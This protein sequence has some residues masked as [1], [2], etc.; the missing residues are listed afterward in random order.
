MRLTQFSLA[1]GLFSALLWSQCTP[2]ASV[3]KTANPSVEVGP[4]TTTVVEDEEGNSAATTK[5]VADRGSYVGES[6]RHWQLKHTKL[7]LKFDWKRRAVIGEATLTL[8]PWFY[9]QDSL[10]LN[11]VGFKN[12][13]VYRLVDR[14][15]MATGKSKPMKKVWKEEPQ[16]FQYRNDKHIVIHFPKAWAKYEDLNL[17][18]S[19]TAI[20]DSVTNGGSAAISQDKGLYFIIPDSTAPDKPYQIWTQGETAGNRKW[21]P[22]IDEPNQRCT[23]EMVLTVDTAYK[24][25]SNGVLQYSVNNQDGTRT[26]AWYMD[27]PHAPY[28]FMLAVGKFAV[29]KDKWKGIDLLYYVEPKFGKDAKA[30]FGRTPAMLDFFSERLGVNYPW[31]KYAQVCVRDYVSGAM[32]NT[33][34]TLHR[35]GVQKSTRE[36]LDADDDGVIA[37]E[38]FHHWF[39]DLV[40]C[41]RW[42]EL[43][44]NESFANYSEYLWLE[45]SKGRDF[46]DVHLGEDLDGYLGESRNKQ[47][48]LIRFYR[49]DFATNE[50]MFDA[51]SYNKGGCT[52]H[53][54]RSIVGDEAFFASLK[55]Y[56]ETHAFSSVEVEDLRLAFEKVTGK[57]LHWFFDQYFKTEG[58]LNVEA[59]TLPGADGA[60]LLLKVKHSKVTEN[61]Y[62]RVPIWISVYN[63]GKLAK[64]FLYTARL[65]EQRVAIGGNPELVLADAE[66]RIVGTVNRKMSISERR[67]MLTLSPLGIHRMAALD[68]LLKGTAGDKRFALGEILQDSSAAVL[69]HT[70]EA[71][72]DLDSLTKLDFVARLRKLSTE[73][74]N[75]EVRALAMNNLESIKDAP[76][77]QVFK[78]SLNAQAPS[79][80]AAGLRGMLALDM[81]EGKSHLEK[82]LSQADSYPTLVVNVAI[83]HVIKKK[84]PGRMDFI[85]GH[86]K[87]AKDFAAFNAW[88]QAGSYAATQAASDQEKFVNAVKANALT[89]DIGQGLGSF[90]GLV[91]YNKEANRPEIKAL[92]DELQK[93]ATGPYKQYYGFIRMRI[94]SGE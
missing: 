33:T 36:V 55:Y 73:H 59:M 39:G 69:I 54:L 26:D 19:Y 16:P 45:K 89:T 81:P 32:E 4:I 93:D 11:A 68:S 43:P 46:A 75:H 15:P 1:A 71:M 17:A 41:E 42:G 24:T 76:S 66:Q 50:E 8:R 3:K 60:E 14:T 91:I 80:E 49:K 47:V 44:M 25:L 61:P 37:H 92:L 51:H 62:F 82:V 2:S 18:I 83:G 67:A 7:E 23:Q 78:R 56:L 90:I 94:E 63:Q 87:K 30:I 10:V 12:L 31:S 9:A 29:V 72:I 38:L 52:L 34:A 48:P 85:L 84:L 74:R 13:E 65:G 35:E 5:K 88:Q 22:T 58:H 70:L 77:A 64:K 27:K 20:P 57:D 6:E 28:L 53:F 40:T 79:E 86:A 21:F